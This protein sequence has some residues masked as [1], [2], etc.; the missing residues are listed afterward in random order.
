VI[1]VV[2]LSHRTAPVEVRERFANGEATLEHVLAR[3]SARKELSEVLYLGTCNRV[4]VMA[5]AAS[6]SPAHHAKALKAIREELADH[7]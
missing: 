5:R 6:D 4:E 1:V 7:G 3:L 2:G